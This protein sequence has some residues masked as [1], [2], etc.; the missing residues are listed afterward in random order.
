MEF[1]STKNRTLMIWI[2]FGKWS[3]ESQAFLIYERIYFR[4]LYGIRR[5]LHI[6]KDGWTPFVRVRK[7]YKSFADP[8]ERCMRAEA[9][10][11]SEYDLYFTWHQSF[12][13]CS[14]CESIRYWRSLNGFIRW[15]IE[16]IWTDRIQKGLIKTF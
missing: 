13:G 7:R 3:S 2:K 12:C 4:R 16:Q 10:Q 14:E 11:E 1:V 15:I 6:N 8:L 9:K 5:F